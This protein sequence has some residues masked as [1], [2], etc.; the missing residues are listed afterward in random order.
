[1]GTN[2]QYDGYQPYD[3]LNASED[4]HGFELAEKTDFEPRTLDLTKDE[5]ERVEKLSQETVLS[6]QD[7]AFQFPADIDEDLFDYIREGRIH[8]AYEFLAETSLDAV[9]DMQLNGLSSVHS[10]RGWKWDDITHEVS[11]RAC[12]LA[13]SDYAF[14]C[15]S[16]DDIHRAREEGRLAVV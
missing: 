4:Y 7:H 5:E 6:L 12:D 16:V 3:Y 13:H 9:F 15:R 11:M 14:Q 10:L 1:M 2:K 8:T